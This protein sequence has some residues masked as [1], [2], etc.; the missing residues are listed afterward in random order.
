MLAINLKVTR[1][2]KGNIYFI[3]SALSGLRVGYKACFF[4]LISGNL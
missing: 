4:I 1:L 3:K 2:S